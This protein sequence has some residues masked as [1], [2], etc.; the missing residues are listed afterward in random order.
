MHRCVGETVGDSWTTY[1]YDIANL[2][3]VS[4]NAPQTNTLAWTYINTYGGGPG[5]NPRFTE[6]SP[7]VWNGCIYLGDNSGR[8]HCIDERSGKEIWFYNIGGGNAIRSSPTIIEDIGL[9]VFG[10]SNNNVYALNA[11]NGVLVWSYTT[12]PASPVRSP[13][14]YAYDR[15]YF[16]TDNGYVYCLFTNGTLNWSRNLANG[17]IRM[18]I[19]A[20]DGR[21]FV[22]SAG[23]FGFG[24]VTA[25]NAY[26]GSVNWTLWLGD[27][28]NSAPTVYN[29]RIYFGCDDGYLYCIDRDI[30]ENL[31]IPSPHDSPI[32]HWRADVADAAGL[33]GGPYQIFSSPAIAN[34]LIYIGTSN[35]TAAATSRTLSIVN[36][37]GAVLGGYY[38]VSG[39]RIEVSPIVVNSNNNATIYFADDTSRVYAINKTG[40]EVWT[41]LTNPAAGFLAAG[42]YANGK[43][44]FADSNQPG[45]LYA[46]GDAVKNVPVAS[47][48][49]STDPITQTLTTVTT[50]ANVTI[51][52]NASASSDPYGA[53]TIAW[54]NFTFADGSYINTTSPL[55]NH[56]YENKGTYYAYV[57]VGNTDGNVSNRTFVRI[58]INNLPPWCEIGP[59][60]TVFVGDTVNFVGNAFDPDGMIT[61]YR[62]DFNGDLVW[63]AFTQN[64]AYTYTTVGDYNVTFQVTDNMNTISRDTLVVHVLP[65]PT[66]P[67]ISEVLVNGNPVA[68]NGA[69][70]VENNTEVV[71]N[72]SAF[73]ADGN[74]EY[75][76][77]DFDNDG[78][79]D[80][81]STNDGNTTFT[82]TELVVNQPITLVVVDNNGTNTTYVIRITVV[83]VPPV[84]DA[85]PEAW[86]AVGEP[87]R[88]DYSAYDP[89]GWIVLYEWDLNAV[90][91]FEWS[92]DRNYTVYWTYTVP[93]D[94]NTRLRVTDNSGD[95]VIKVRVIHV[96]YTANQ[97]PEAIVESTVI[98][99]IV[100]ETAYFNGSG[101]DA[102][103]TIVSYEWDFGDGTPS[104]SSSIEGN[105]THTY[106]AEG[107]YYAT[108]TVTDN[109][110]RK[111]KINVVV[112]VTNGTVAHNE[113]PQ[114]YVEYT[115]INA[116]VNENVYLNGS[117]IDIDGWV[118]QYEWNFGDG[119]MLY[120]DATNG[121]TTHVYTSIGTYTAK[122]T[123]FDNLGK[124]DSKTVIVIVSD[125]STPNKAPRAFPGE[126]IAA[127]VNTQVNFTGY[128]G[129]D[130][131]GTI[132][133]YE[134]DFDGDGTYDWSNA[135]NITATHVYTTVGIYTAR[136]QVTDNLGLT[137][138]ATIT[139]TITEGEPIL[140]IA[141][142][143]DAITVYVNTQVQFA[144]TGSSPASVS[145]V[146]YEW[147]F[148]GDGIYDWSNTSA[149]LVSY[150]YNTVGVYNAKL[151]VTDANGLS[152]TA[153]RTVTVN[154]APPTQIVY[155]NP[156]V[157]IGPD[158]TI[159]EGNEIDFAASII[160]TDGNPANITKYTW[161]FGDGKSGSNAF[162]THRFE[163]AGTYTVTLTIVDS[164][165]KTAQDSLT[166]TVN[167]KSTAGTGTAGVDPL[168][169]TAMAIALILALFVIIFLLF[170]RKPGAPATASSEV[171]PAEAKPVE[172]EQPAKP[173]ETPK[174]VKP[175]TPA[176]IE[177]NVAKVN[178]SAEEKKKLLNEK[179]GESEIKP[180]EIV[181]ENK[182][183]M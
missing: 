40:S 138:N 115:T 127:K 7:V 20:D 56:S 161:N 5:N 44:Y 144:G 50:S 96:N 3:N 9:V 165:G 132:V 117:G 76:T 32:I 16:G 136:L 2:G 112:I 69:V 38:T 83:N 145:I 149:G 102:D 163:K 109:E 22:A 34:D 71:L 134:W 39:R 87:V 46:F 101:S 180:A 66:P 154:S 53:G 77:W 140:P 178:D 70:T 27:N 157:Y 30:T 43:V 12:V 126:N 1:Q 80:Y 114:G 59:D 6:S 85:G 103:G 90:G 160:Y 106:T 128:Y 4:G 168:C 143:G 61:Q 82:P 31:T 172:E 162:E 86:V 174:E 166:V 92:G 155:G 15:I 98:N 151:R 139:V 73:D 89:D 183:K 159:V 45:R 158:K 88:F 63:D 176:Q 110:G 18:A 153:I 91:G 25:L 129:L 122:F 41:Y 94:Y 146:L 131:D 108:Y 107:T 11:S 169:A 33:Y 65:G 24:T 170:F 28:A 19:A 95:A 182:P 133:L 51:Y 35:N 17:N 152:A 118:V 150:I 42:A 78:L 79:P 111:T 175:E 173:I 181:G 167:K 179:V 81:N 72:V 119:S 137:A 37:T 147:D 68:N 55:V 8:F 67:I 58:V 142:A 60:I 54:Y 116:I 21:V 29:G 93:G 100:N 148:N 135:N 48:L 123:V 52:F 141:N 113:P 104:W 75:Y 74:I 36:M 99:A 47:L 121:N 97:A 105:T 13:I 124:N 49:I 171:I 26:N 156:S 23:A 14:T 130:D 84:V 62:W 10:A 120:T 177:T 57:V 125:G 164:N 64:A